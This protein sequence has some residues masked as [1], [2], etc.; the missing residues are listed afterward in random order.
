MVKNGKKIGLALVAVVLTLCVG[1]LPAFAQPEFPYPAGATFNPPY[2]FSSKLGADSIQA[3]AAAGQEATKW[4]SSF[5]DTFDGRPIQ[6]IAPLFVV[7]LD[8]SALATI[9]V[10]FEGCTGF[11]YVIY[12]TAGEV[13][14]GAGWSDTTFAGVD[15]GGGAY[16]NALYVSENTAHMTLDLPANSNSFAKSPWEW[17]ASQSAGRYALI[18]GRIVYNYNPSFGAQG[19]VTANID[20]AGAT[21][22][23]GIDT[24]WTNAGLAFDGLLNGGAS[25]EEL[26]SAYNDGYTAG[27]ADGY[28]SGYTAGDSNGYGRGYDDGYEDGEEYGFRTGYSQGHDEGYDQGYDQGYKDINQGAYDEGYGAGFGA[29]QGVGYS[30][31]YTAGYTA[32]EEVGYNNG[33]RAGYS[34]TP[35]D[36][37]VDSA[38]NSFFSGLH[39][40]FDGWFGVEIFGISVAGTLIG[41]LIV[42][43][44]A[45]VVKKLV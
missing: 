40:I 19:L 12:C 7:E 27:Q 43:I 36:L 2:T 5:G 16:I 33:Y 24:A 35:V 21:G 9:D 45:F 41:I 6:Q 29:G 31:G 10:Q 17:F 14:P 39:S 18:Y 42:C 30:T 25:E 37:D 28:S 20:P 23:D 26:D 44:V 13:T 3:I 4:L 1:I 38:V 8:Y 11:G 32:G 34:E 22:H 15:Y